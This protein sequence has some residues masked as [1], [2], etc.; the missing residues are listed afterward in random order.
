MKYEHDTIEKEQRNTTRHFFK[1]W[2]NHEKSIEEFKGKF[3]ENFRETK[4][5]EELG[6]KM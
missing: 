5:K 3:V 1:K 4:E 6:K 2:S